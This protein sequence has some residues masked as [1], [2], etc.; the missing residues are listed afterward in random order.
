MPGFAHILTDEQIAEL[1]AYLRTRFSGQPA[2]NDVK[3]MS[4]V[5]APKT[6]CDRR[7]P[8]ARTRIAKG[9]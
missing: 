2:W 4:P 3:G 8:P 7:I 5:S 6:G 1:A 9:E